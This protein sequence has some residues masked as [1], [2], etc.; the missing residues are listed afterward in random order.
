[1]YIYIYI[2]IYI[3]LQRDK[4]LRPFYASVNILSVK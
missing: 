4:D 1:M 2:Y 3:Y